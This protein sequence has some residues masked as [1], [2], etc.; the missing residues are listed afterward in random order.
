MPRED[1]HL[2]YGYPRKGHGHASITAEEAAGICILTVIL[3][4]LLLVGCWYCR[5]R[6]GYRNLKDKS[7]QAGT[8]S[9]LTG[10]CLCKQL[11]HQDSKLPFQVHNLWTSGRLRSC[12]LV[13]DKSILI[14]NKQTRV[15]SAPPAYEKLSVQQSLPP[16]LP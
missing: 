12:I 13:F 16:Y 1:A 5:R 6:S 11:A 7:L 9:A 8:Q 10:R 3:G 2:I 15:P 4:I 14:K